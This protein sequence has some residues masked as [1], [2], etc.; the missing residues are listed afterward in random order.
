[1]PTGYTAGIIDGKI[2]T[3]QD[4]AKQCMRAFGACIHMRDEDYDKNYEPRLPSDYH[5]KRIEKSKEEIARINSISDEDLILTRK[6][7]IETEIKRCKDSISKQK[8]NRNALLSIKSDI[9][10]WTPPTSEHVGIKDFM[11]E[12]IKVTIEGDCD[13][14]YYLKEIK[15]LQSKLIF[16]DAKDERRRML[17]LE[18]SR[19]E[20]GKVEYEKEVKRCNDA[21]KWITDLLDSIKN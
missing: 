18:N 17:E 12:Q 13:P 3:F 2:N 19:I 7:E 8:K 20:Y 16:L 10:D 15:E 5:L 14:R 9:Q 4:F 11:L 1:M 6:V 21:N